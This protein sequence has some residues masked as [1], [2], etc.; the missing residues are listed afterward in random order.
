[1]LFKKQG[2]PEEGD[3]VLCTVTSVQFHSVFVNIEEYGRS[4][5]I[6]ISE[7]SPGRIRNIR[8][9]VKEGKK[10]VCKVLRIN[11]EKGYIDLSLRRVNEGEKRKKIDSIKREQNSEKIVEL[12]AGKIGKKTEEL[13]KEIS[14]K[15]SKNYVSFHDFFEEASKNEKVLEKLGIDRKNLKIISDTIKQRIKPTEVEIKGKLKITTYAPDGIGLIRESLKKAE[16]AGKGK[17]II[18][19][20]GS[21]LYRFMIKA[22][23]YKEAE[24]LMKNAT[25]KAINIVEKQEGF[26]E[27]N[28]E[29]S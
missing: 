12:A 1:M 6:H 4:G 22:P 26:A 7:V 21:G 14:E 9:F 27:F 8:D 11:Q 19:Y 17:I 24:K 10:I 23:D 18:N 29:G 5:M 25:E 2:F 13:Y 3:L 20:L 16:E 28:R 15:I